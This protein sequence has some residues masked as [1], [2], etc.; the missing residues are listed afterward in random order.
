[1]QVL[2]RQLCI[3]SYEKIYI[4]IKLLQSGCHM[5]LLNKNGVAMKLVVFFWK[6]VKMKDIITIDETL[7]RAYEPEVKHQSAEW[8]HEGSP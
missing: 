2:I 3:K 5:H 7:V 8:R 6:G 4:C 1:M